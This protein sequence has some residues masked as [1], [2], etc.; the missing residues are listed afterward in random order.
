MAS[1]G[2]SLTMLCPFRVA[3]TTQ[4]ALGVSSASQDTTGMPNKGHHMIASHALAMESPLLASASNPCLYLPFPE[5]PTPPSS[6]ALLKGSGSI[7]A[8][9]LPQC[10]VL[11]YDNT[12]PFWASTSSS[13]KWG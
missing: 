12:F 13:V 10:V 2:S 5:M 9:H 8:L 1:G 3:S 6:Q 4:R 7:L 11:R